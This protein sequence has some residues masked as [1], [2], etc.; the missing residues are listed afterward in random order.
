[1][2]AKVAIQSTLLNKNGQGNPARSKT[3]QMILYDLFWLSQ[4][5]LKYFT[6]GGFR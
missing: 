6:G 3:G 5:A 2:S 1:M 4:G